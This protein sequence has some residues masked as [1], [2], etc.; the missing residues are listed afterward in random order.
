MSPERSKNKKPALGTEP[1]DAGAP[2]NAPERVRKPHYD[3]EH[4][5]QAESEAPRA[6]TP[7]RVSAW[8]ENVEAWIRR[9]LLLADPTFGER[10]DDPTPA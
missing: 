3:W 9:Y 7:T 8:K 5:S 2:L 10:D 4:E 6:K 1:N